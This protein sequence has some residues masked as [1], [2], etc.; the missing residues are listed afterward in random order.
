ME[1]NKFHMLQHKWLDRS[2]DA[3]LRMK[4]VL[5][6]TAIAFSVVWQLCVS[7]LTLVAFFR[8]V[9]SLYYSGNITVHFKEKEGKTRRC[10]LLKLEKQ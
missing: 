10:A 1:P 4:R 9:V 6:H 2:R 7:F 3:A 8:Q 5:K